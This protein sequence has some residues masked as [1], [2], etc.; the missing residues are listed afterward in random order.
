MN[1]LNETTACHPK[2][3]DS[4]RRG[5]C[6]ARDEEREVPGPLAHGIWCSLELL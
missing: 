1:V 2:S 5:A 4:V 3:R 6:L